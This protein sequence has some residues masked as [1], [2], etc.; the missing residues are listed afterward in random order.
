M[1]VP[2]SLKARLIAVIE[3]VFALGMGSVYL[4]ARN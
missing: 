3:L 4:A 1:R 2:L